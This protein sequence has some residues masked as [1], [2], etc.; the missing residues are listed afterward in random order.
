[1]WN[2]QVLVN[3]ASLT[4]EEKYC[5]FLVFIVVLLCR[6]FPFV[7]GK[8]IPSRRSF[9]SEKDKSKKTGKVR[10]KASLGILII[11]VLLGLCAEA[12]AAEPNLVSWWKFDDNVNDSSGNGYHGTII[13][14]PIYVDGKVGQAL[15][16]DGIDDYVEVTGLTHPVNMT[17][18]LW[19]KAD[20]FAGSYNYITLL[21]FGSDDPW[22]GIYSGKL[23]FWGRRKYVTSNRS[24]TIGRWYHI[25]VTSDGV[26]SIIYING[27]ADA[28]GKPNT[29]TGTGLGIGY[30]S[31]DTHF[32]GVIDEI[33]IFDRALSSEEILQ[34]YREGLYTAYNPEPKDGATGIDPDMVLSWFPGKDA[35]SHDV[36]FGTNYNDVTDADTNSPEYMGNQYGNGY[37]PVGLE[38]DTTYYWR[39]DEVNDANTNS[40]WKGDVWSFTTWA[41]EITDVYWAGNVQGGVIGVL[42]DV[43]PPAWGEWRC[44]L[45]GEE[46]PM[47]GDEEVTFNIH[48][49]DELE[50]PPTGL[51]I[52]T[53]PWLSTVRNSDFPC[54]GTLQ[55]YIPG[56]GLTNLY[57]FDLIDN[58]CDTECNYYPQA[59]NPIPN[60]G[61]IS[62]K[63]GTELNWTPGTDAVWHDVYLGT[64]YSDV[65]IATTAMPLGV[66]KGS[67]ASASYIPT[68]TADTIYYWRID[69]VN[70]N[71]VIHKGKI[72][73][74]TTAPFTA[75][76][77]RP[78]DGARYVSIE[79]TLSW[80][81]GFD[82]NSHDVYFGTSTSPPFQ[83]NQT[84]TAYEPCMMDV[85]TTYYWRIDEVG[86]GGTIT[87]E[88]WSFTTGFW[89]SSYDLR[90]DGYVT[91]VKLQWG[92]T[93]WT[94]GAMAALESNLLITGNWFIAREYGEPDLAEYHLDWWNGF[95][96][97]NNDDRDP[98]TGGGVT[99]HMGGDY[100]M[101]S[102]YL[103]RGEG[104]VRDIDGDSYNTPPL[105]DSNS[106]HK[107]YPHHIEWYVLEDDLSNIGII[108]DK[109]YNHGALGT[110]MSWSYAFY[111]HNAYYHPPSSPG[112]VGHAVAIVGW[113]DNKVTQAPQ[114]GAWLCKNS[115]GRIWGEDGYFWMS[116]YDKHCCRNPQMGAVSFQD[117]EMLAY[118]HIYYHDYH[119]WRDTMTSVSEAFN[120]FIATDQEPITAV[121]FYTAADN[122]T[123]TV[124][125]YDRF[126]GGELLDVLSTKA[127]SFE[128]TGFHT[129]DLGMPVILT[130]NDDFYIYLELSAGGQ[131]YDRTSTVDVLLG[132]PS[133][134]LNFEDSFSQEPAPVDR[135]IFSVADYV[136]LYKMRI[137]AGGGPLVES[138]SEPGQSFYRSG[139][140][141]HD[142]YNFNNTANFCIKALSGEIVPPSPRVISPVDGACGVSTDTILNWATGPGAGLH[143]PEY[144]DLYFGTDFDDVNNADSS[145]PVGSSVYKG[146]FPADTNSFD[147]GGLELDTWYYWRIDEV[148]ESD[149]NSPYKGAVWSFTTSEIVYYVPD[150]YPTIQEAIDSACDGATIIVGEGTYYE[151]II[152]EGKSLTII[153]TEP[154]D[155][156]VVA[157][158]VIDGNQE[159][160]VV[161]FYDC[162]E[163]IIFSGFT[164]VNGNGN[165]NY[166]GG[167]YCSFS[168]PIVTNC[169][170]IGN[171]AGGM[172]NH[173]NSS[174]TVTNCMFSGNSGLHVGMY[175]YWN[176]S[177]T[178]TNCTFIGNSAGGMYNYWN[179]SPTVTNC[180]FIGNTGRGMSND[181]NSSPTVTNCMFS[182]N[183]NRGMFNNYSSPTVANCTFSG[184]S[185][186]GMHNLDSNPVV[187]NC[188]FSGNSASYGG[189]MYNDEGNPIV[190]NCTFSGNLASSSG[191]GLYDDY[192]SS[193]TVTN[194]TFI[195][196]SA[197]GYGGGA[198]FRYKT[199]TLTNCIFWGNTAPTGSQIQYFYEPSSATVTYSDVQ[200]GWPGVG[201]TDAD[202]CFVYAGYWDVNDMWVEGDYHLLAGSPCIDAGDPN[203]VAGP[204]ETDLDG[205]P[206]VVDGDNDGNSVLDM[207][208]YERM[209]EP[210][211]LILDLADDV[212]A[213]NLHKGI[214]NSLEAKL[215]AALGALEDENENNDAA[216]INTLGAFINAVEAQ[217]GKKIPQAEADALIAAAQQIIELL[218]D[219]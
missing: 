123:Y 159:G 139:G 170:F 30:Y 5:F 61:A 55:F 50:A 79:A 108:K 91:P 118:D 216:A 34:L 90:D 8:R 21:E 52:G 22:L 76:N 111:S 205:N 59:R 168:N 44:Y 2:K 12:S 75:S 105:R 98:P 38:K 9:L 195:G 49:N 146:R 138:A 103:T 219:G 172:D 204:N 71:S 10:N 24:F 208:A 163:D 192:D 57:K 161:Q 173:W 119:G 124:R 53:L 56:K 25:A 148:N 99:V 95:N 18:A 84:E 16:F 157:A 210:A 81:A 83:G 112:G 128:H 54:M 13:G 142:L 190:T 32:D 28:T 206:R 129:V 165:S 171:S 154:N 175:N 133:P 178:V 23:E 37:Y 179:S 127:G 42:L 82:A 93:C 160:S 209:P 107:Y 167:I 117:V 189:G 19:V 183:S 181:W 69:E 110:C 40:P 174:P 101:T 145:W 184:N 72:W 151:N 213:L 156:N 177:P 202:P 113:D 20:A 135:E 77:P 85:N 106:Y 166:G 66:Y 11:T 211:E 87:G 200:G 137:L 193:S 152:I 46:V 136:R 143:E 41:I 188:I 130:E 214:T 36:Y 140:T 17:Y 27:Q 86:P 51:W 120:A 65:K 203:Y 155:P 47:F 212:M 115:W 187:T 63:A 29:Q 104:A 26:E 162:V 96:Q 94:H 185:N 201:N 158:T 194:C 215:N 80:D 58:G 70:D 15:D 182:G 186:H 125:I 197:G 169:T 92:G 217:R 31:G 73:N 153:S 78:A 48:P 60:D 14:A 218:S 35:A 114:A 64:N 122:V 7:E 150:D 100:L 88:L 39:I 97:H 132:P 6:V 149:A 43:W 33:K 74:F 180:T 176:S 126:E 116:Y 134:E 144:Y 199:S 102:A 109:I 1:M 68:L 131:A 62:V 3:T 207:G 191:G 45:N 147:P 67:E 164:L 141:W 198:Y 89:G 121:S 4:E 196:N